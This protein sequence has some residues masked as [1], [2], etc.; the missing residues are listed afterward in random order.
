MYTTVMKN[1]KNEKEKSFRYTFVVAVI[2]GLN[3]RNLIM[4]SLLCHSVQCSA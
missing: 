4:I 3:V 1:T 2:S